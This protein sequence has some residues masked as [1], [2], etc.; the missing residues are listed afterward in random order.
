MKVFEPLAA[1][2]PGDRVAVG[3]AGARSVREL[4]RDVSTLAEQL[5]ACDGELLVACQDRYH[6]AVALLAAWQCRIVV[7]L[8][9]NGR[10]QTLAALAERC[11]RSWH[12][13]EGPG[14][15]V[16]RWLSAGQSAPPLERLAGIPAERAVV[17]VYTSGS[18]GAPS[19]C[20]KTAQQLLG[21]GETLRQTFELAADSCVLATVPAHHIYGLLFSIVLPLSAG[22]RFVR[23]TPL[24]MPVIEEL[25]RRH[26][27]DVLISVPAHL[28]ALARS[29]LTSLAS[30]RAI[31]S[32]GAALPASTALELHAKFGVPVREVLGSTETG[33]F[34]WRSAEQPDAP[35]RPF[36]NVQ[37]SVGDDEQLLL[38]SP[39]LDAG[40][41]QP[42]ACPDRIELN[43]DGS[44]RHI[45]RTDGVIKVA[46]TR[47]SLA[48]LEGRVRAVSGVRDA[49]ALAV[50]G[51]PARG[52][53][54][55]L[56]VAT[57]LGAELP[58]LRAELLR[59][60]EPVVLPRRTRFVTALPREAT[61]KLPREQL[62]SLFANP[63]PESSPSPATSPAAIS[64]FRPCVLVPSYDNPDTITQVVQQIRSFVSDV[65]VVDD[66][67]G[68]R[69]R[70]AIETLGAAGLAHVVRHERN[71]G[72]GAA[73]KSGFRAAQALGFTHALQVDADGQHTLEDIPR[74]LETAAQDPACLVLGAPVFDDSVPASRLYGRRISVFWAR[75]ETA[76][77]VVKDPLCGFRVYPLASALACAPRADR[78]DFDPEIAVR[79]VWNGVRVQNLETRVRYVP[80]EHGGVS[81]FRLVRDNFR[82]SLMHTR[83]CWLALL[84]AVTGRRL[85]L[86]PNDR[87]NPP[88]SP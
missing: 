63:K 69:A 11:A 70:R 48:E 34:A 8:P 23:D 31:F 82:I 30:I 13:G 2:A 18:T 7:A 53:E 21:E 76:G 3:E 35:F 62:L 65:V 46:G 52:Q 77:P 39:L 86:L 64:G 88:P 71:A 74:F 57:E 15:D 55:W 12:D 51:G 58:E 45:G 19:A 27:A 41:A 37:I 14:D 29:P 56:V 47:V 68:E 60:Y 83:L 79:M 1:Y 66:G 36:P 5:G 87:P 17:T 40:I 28:H 42:L 72:K 24:H 20:R 73:V 80:R 10:E 32:S 4:L 16:R 78:M 44:F 38:R 59:H 81:H 6:L 33:G 26:A 54:L 67:S 61:G 22:A 9:P 25:A 75:I 43:P 49:A 84:R 85:A 50:D